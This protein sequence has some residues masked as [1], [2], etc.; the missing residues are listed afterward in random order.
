[1]S[2]KLGQLIDDL[3]A[4]HAANE[5]VFAT[6]AT[7]VWDR[8]THAPGWAVRDQ[9]AHLAYFD[10][11]AARIIGTGADAFAD[12]RRGG[13][14]EPSFLERGR[15]MKPEQLLTWW[16]TASRDLVAAAR[17]ADPARR[18]PW[19][20]D[21]SPASFLSARLMEAWS[22]GLDVVDVVDA[23]RPDADRLRHVALIGVNTRPHSYRTRGITMPSAPVRVELVLPSGEP[24]VWG[25]PDA[26][27]RIR[28][29]ATDFCRV[30]TQRRH[31]ADTGLEIMGPAAAEWMLVAQAFAGPPG[32]GRQPGQFAYERPR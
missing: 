15:A 27:D 5:A 14:R 6:L 17:T 2:L 1:M 7:D 29:M 26:Q 13:A 4:E 25:D 32:E 19:G 12:Q 20:R 9:V 16:R 23:A 22:H 18:L 8:P 21:M 10:E 3:A 28:G 24:W 30:V 31:V 11:L